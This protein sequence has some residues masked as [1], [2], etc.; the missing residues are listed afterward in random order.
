[1]KEVNNFPNYLITEDGD[2]YNTKGLKLKKQV[3]IDGYFVVN[4]YNKDG[5]FH[6]RICRLVAEAYLPNYSEDLVVNHKDLNKQNDNVSNLEM[7]TSAENTRH[8]ILNQPHKHRGNALLTPEEVNTVRGLLVEGHT[9]K[10]VVDITGYSIDIVSRIRRGNHKAV[11]TDLEIPKAKRLLCEDDVILICK[12]LNECGSV[13][14]V[15]KVLG[16]THITVDSIR[17]IKNRKC[18]KK[19]SDIYL[20]KPSSTSV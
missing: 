12:L 9:N 20:E 15:L 11:P 10:E 8:S 14:K 17:H 6:K 19:V 3:N 18:W 2:L 5:E 16:E 7:I 13:A 4:I 1:M